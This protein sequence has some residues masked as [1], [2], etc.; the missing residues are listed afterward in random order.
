[1]STVK[2]A[3]IEIA[4]K[5]GWAVFPARIVEGGAKQGWLKAWEGDSHWRASN[6]PEEI[7]RAFDVAAHRKWR[8]CLPEDIG[9][10]IPTGPE[11][12]LFVIDV[13]TKT[14]GHADDG[15]PVLA[16]LEA[17]NGPLPA[18]L[19]SQSPTGSVHYYFRYP[20]GMWIKHSCSGPGRAS[21]LGFGIDV[22][23]DNHM[24]VAPPTRRPMGAYKW[25]NDLPVAD[26]P[27]W[28]LELVRGT[29]PVRAT[30]ANRDAPIDEI[31][32]ALSMIPSTNL[33]FEQWNRI[34]MAVYGASGGSK[35]GRDLFVAWS[36]RAPVFDLHRNLERWS[37]YHDSP[38]KWV[39]IQTLRWEAMRSLPAAYL[40][41]LMRG[42]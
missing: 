13:D 1:M 8:F 14:G 34:G 10:G 27:A 25:L 2:T 18:T 30:S 11:N 5:Y 20:Q 37:H 23:S 16:A 40:A 32:L 33:D 42:I 28:L 38:P 39:G 3:A 22:F 15:A 9:I 29:E 36:S 7:E 35:E 26:P 31:E 12:Q 4:Q 41:R 19:M 21:V 17:K 24:V 6:I